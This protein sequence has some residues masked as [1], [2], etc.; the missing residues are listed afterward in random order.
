MHHVPSCVHRQ[1]IMAGQRPALRLVAVL[2][3]IMF[4]FGSIGIQLFGGRVTLDTTSEDYKRECPA[5]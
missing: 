2:L 3:A 5:T 4:F 1:V